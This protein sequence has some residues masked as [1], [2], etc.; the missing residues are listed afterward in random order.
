MMRV[1]ES[2]HPPGR[3]VTQFKTGGGLEGTKTLVKTKFR[4]FNLLHSLVFIDPS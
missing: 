3:E 4:T 1:N 2:A